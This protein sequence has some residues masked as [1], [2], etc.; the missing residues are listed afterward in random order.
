M[1]VELFPFQKTAVADLREK[2]A[3]SKAI[4]SAYKKPQVISLT[5]PTGAGKTIIA[6]ALIES[7]Y[8]GDFKYESQ[9]NAIIV[10]LS[11][12]PQLNEQSKEK[13]ER[14]CD[15]LHNQLVTIAEDSFDQEILSDGTI[16]FLN[17]QKL[18]KS[19]NLVKHS[20]SRQFTIWETLQNTILDKAEQ[21]YFIIDE[22]HR[23][24]RHASFAS[25]WLIIQNQPMFV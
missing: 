22:A 6:S 7:I 9:Q 15:K 23:G 14:V 2:C 18:G 21:L 17:T 13:I 3:V 11:D 25:H 10:W 16:Y 8:C 24:A 20:D 5:A 4:Y 1:K 19:S 12:S